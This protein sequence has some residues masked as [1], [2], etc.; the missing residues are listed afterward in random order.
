MQQ[1]HHLQTLFLPMQHSTYPLGPQN[2]HLNTPTTVQPKTL[3]LLPPH[4]KHHHNPAANK[5][6][7]TSTT[8]PQHITTPHQNHP[9][10]Q[11]RTPFT[12][13]P[14]QTTTHKTPPKQATH[15]TL[16]HKH[17]PR[18][19]TTYNQE[20]NNSRYCKSMKMSSKT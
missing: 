1:T 16:H 8:C 15:S 18:L 3:D 20:T 2:L 7:P 4:T 11:L 13:N 17:K 12:H 9:S 6:E 10:K 14:Q 19:P 5:S